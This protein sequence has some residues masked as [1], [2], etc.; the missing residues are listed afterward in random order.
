[1]EMPQNIHDEAAYIS[2]NFGV[3]LTTALEITLE[4]AKKDARKKKRVDR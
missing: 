2:E 3:P 4:K 1:M